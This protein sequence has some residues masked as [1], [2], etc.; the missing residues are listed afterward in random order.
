M[1]TLTVPLPD[2]D[3][4]ALERAARA[5][6]RSLTQLAQDVLRAYQDRAGALETR[7][8]LIDL[9]VLDGPRPVGE[10]PSRAEVYEEIWSDRGGER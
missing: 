9:P 6:E 7:S 10:L 3:Y 8:R 1:K 4:E 5:R 2:S